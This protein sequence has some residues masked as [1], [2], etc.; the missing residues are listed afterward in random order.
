MARS[1]RANSV[2]AGRPHATDRIVLNRERDPEQPA[3]G[4]VAFG[5]PR[6]DRPGAPRTITC[7][8]TPTR[9]VPF[10]AAHSTLARSDPGLLR[11]V[12]RFA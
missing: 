2:T 10:R 11:C 9:A 4:D 6:V 5:S 1:S 7:A 12:V 3:S 8:L